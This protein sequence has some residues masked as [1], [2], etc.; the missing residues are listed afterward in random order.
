[1]CA[2]GAF[3]FVDCFRP[4]AFGHDQWGRILPSTRSG[5]GHRLA[6]LNAAAGR[7]TRSDPRAQGEPMAHLSHRVQLHPQQAQ[8]PV[9]RR[10]RRGD[11]RRRPIQLGSLL[12]CMAIPWPGH[13]CSSLGGI[14]SG[15]FQARLGLREYGYDFGI[16]RR[17]HRLDTP[18]LGSAGV[19]A[20]R[21]GGRRSCRRRPE[22]PG[23]HRRR[24]A[25]KTLRFVARHADIWHTFVQG[26]DLGPQDRGPAR[27][28]RAR[29]APA[30]IEVSVG[31]GGRGREGVA[32]PARGQAGLREDLG[33]SPVHDRAGRPGPR[34][35]GSRALA[36]LARRPQRQLSQNL[37][38]DPV[39][40]S[41]GI[42]RPR[43][44]TPEY[45][46]PR[47][48]VSLPAD[49]LPGADGTRI[50]AGAVQEARSNAG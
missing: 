20:D 48:G 43:A 16:R 28:L 37:I 39:G 30:E 25:K 47:H 15:W 33:A 36:R 44:D 2:R 6:R 9:R 14:G 17:L 5:G 26:A 34:P 1:M 23:A 21:G 3:H 45:A 42:R 11:G 50:P 13:E 7:V 27:A 22:D 35:L 24:G 46:V 31:V 18:W 49:I 32:R 12:P 41:V 8:L 19:A 29:E 38:R 10:R 4:F 40:A